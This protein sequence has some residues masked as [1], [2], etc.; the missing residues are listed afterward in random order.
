[1]RVSILNR[2]VAAE[3][4]PGFMVNILV[5]TSILLMARMMELTSL[6][7][8]KGVGLDVVAKIFAMALP[9]VL[10]MAL[11][12]GTLLAVLMAFLRFSADSEL[13]VLRASGVS[14][15]QMSPPV[16]VFGLLVGL[17]TGVFSV[18][19]APEYNWKFKNQLLELAKARADLAITEQVFVR[20]FPGLVF[21]VGQF[22]PGSGE[23]EKVFIHDD[24]SEDESSVIVARRGRLGLDLES[25]ALIFHL[26]DGVID[27]VYA[28]RE[29]SDSIFFETYELKV[30]P[31]SEFE[32][33]QGGGEF[34]GR[35]EVP[36]RELIALADSLDR[37]NA[38]GII[39]TCYLEWHRRWAQPFTAF[40][41]AVI[42]LPLGASFR[43]RGRN[44]AL[45]IG[46]AVFIGYYALFTL[47]WSLAER[48][49]LPPFMGVWLSNIVLTV[50][51]LA[52]LRRINCGAPGDPLELLRRI[53][54]GFGKPRA[55]SQAR[56]A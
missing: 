7:I 55:G 46:I 34:R 12:M 20:N 36:T 26:E 2:Y 22:P 11:P 45:I 21:Y 19:L 23:M 42:G 49:I 41:M 4:L 10:A 14:L 37:E 16:L 54:S 31:G 35:A 30:S 6:V 32:G 24:R 13:T 3:I 44:F 39:I 28:D 40:I 53:I 50:F 33:N 17:L 18:W 38:R 8:S 15:Y 25:E 52:T 47:G 9:R 29:T 48:E 1:M 43:V 5:F 56:P 51:G 27:R